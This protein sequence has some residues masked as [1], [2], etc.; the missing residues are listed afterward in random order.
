MTFTC[1]DAQEDKLR[2]EMKATGALVRFKIYEHEQ[3][4]RLSTRMSMTTTTSNV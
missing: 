1:T 3:N 4:S 2:K